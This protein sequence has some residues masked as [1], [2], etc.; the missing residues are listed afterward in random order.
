MSNYDQSWKK[1]D[2]ISR[3]DELLSNQSKYEEQISATKRVNNEQLINKKGFTI[4][5]KDKT[6]SKVIQD[7]YIP[8]PKVSQAKSITQCNK[9]ENIDSFHQDP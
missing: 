4:K 8:T 1:V 6:F 5:I 9:F 2:Q 3:Y 7:D